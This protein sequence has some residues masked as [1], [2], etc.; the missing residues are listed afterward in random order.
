MPTALTFFA[1]AGGMCAGL[2]RSG[3][4]IVGGNEWEVRAA[5]LAALQGFPHDWQW[6]G[7]EVIAAKAIGNA[8]P[9]PLGRA[10]GL[11]LLDP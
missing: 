2:A 11:S 4:G 8:V 3:F 10:I 7:A 5:G 1:G 9:I 6:P